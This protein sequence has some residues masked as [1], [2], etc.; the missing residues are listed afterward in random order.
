MPKICSACTLINHIHRHGICF[1]RAT[2]FLQVW[3]VS[4][5]VD[6]PRLV[7]TVPDNI[8]LTH[9][10]FAP[11]LPVLVCGHGNGLLSV[12]RHDGMDTDQ[13]LSIEE[14]RGRLASALQTA[15]A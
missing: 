1:T 10:T 6:R 12:L 8:A 3:D 2:A 15:T 14:Q 11:A 4:H 5:A 13:H 9:L 7:H